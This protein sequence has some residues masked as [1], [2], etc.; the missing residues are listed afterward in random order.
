MEL[1][2][3]GSLQKVLVKQAEFN[4]GHAYTYALGVA[5]GIAYLHSGSSPL[6]IMDLSIANTQEP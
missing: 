1:C 4:W 3:Q 5:K 6:G 2:E